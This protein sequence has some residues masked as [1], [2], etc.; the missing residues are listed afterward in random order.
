MMSYYNLD[1]EEVLTK[2]STNREG[3]KNIEVKNR[4]QKYGKNKLKIIKKQS[5]IKK[6]LCQFKDIMIIILILS[7]IVSFVLSIINNESFT[8]SIIIL[9]IVIINAIVGYIQESKADKALEELKKLQTTKTKVKR[10][11]RIIEI[12]SEDIV[13]GDI[14]VLEAGDTVP[15]DARIIYE[16]RLKC[17]ESALTG[18]SCNI[19]KTSRKLNELEIPLQNRI[20]MIYSGT[21][22]TYGKCQA[23][24]TSTGM[25]TEF[26]LIAKS[27][28]TEEKEITPLERKINDISKFLSIIIFII[29]FIMFI[30]GLIK[31]MKI[32]EVIM[33]SISLAVAAI[34]EGLPAVITI[35]L[36]LG[37]A[38]MARKKAIVRKLSSVETLGCTEVICSDK[39][40]TITQNKMTV[41]G[42]Y[43]DNK[44][45][46]SKEEI[47]ND[48]LEIM[49]LNNDVEK[50]ENKYI[51][52]STEIAL[53]NICEE[54]LVDI[55][56]LRN[57]FSRIDELPFDSDRKMMST[58]NKYDKC[59]KILTKGSFD[60]IINCCTKIYENGNINDLNEN[61]KQKL[62][63][64]E[65]ELSNKAYRILAF[66]FKEI[67]NKYTL[68]NNLENNLIFVGMTLMIDPPRIDVKEAINECK[69]A[70]IKPI[71]ITGDSL[72]T[73]I[74][75]SKEI[76]ILNDRKE[77][78]TG[79]E[80]DKL[81]KKELK[82]KVK[83]YSVYARVSPMN[84]LQI[85]NAWK[86]NNV[87]VA[88][89]GDGVNDAPA[90]KSAN[91]G[92]GM[93]ITGTEVS[94]NVSDIILADDSFSTIVTAVEEGRRIYDNIRNV[95]VYL[96]TGNIAEV[97]VVFI[98]MLFGIEIF[99]P[100]QLLYINLITDSIPAIALS[101][102]ECSDG[103]M[104]RTVK[105]NTNS[106][107]TPFLLAKIF[108]SSL[109]K[110][111]VILFVYF[112][113]INIYGV[114]T[115][116]T[117]SFLCL[118][119]LEMIFAFTCRNLKKNIIFEGIFKNK[120]MNK[121]M[122]VLLL[123]QTFIFVTPLKRI[124]NIENL[125][126]FQIIYCVIMVLTIFLIDEL[127][128]NLLV[129]IFKD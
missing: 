93:G 117:M 124:F 7:S 2:L 100:I 34:P 71:M 68:D 102:E 118:I 85:V 61:K 64:K 12:D 3:L 82:E 66:A 33:L 35:T 54:H 125:S 31:G 52:D 109:L 38:S 119:L 111:L 99:L 104:K 23:V 88:M 5:K 60:S 50:F 89:T 53:Y 80:I 115:A 84:K 57:K 56:D 72:D 24:V 6:F 128:K 18:E 15:A 123:I 48:L 122:I 103:I 41:V 79:I 46:D 83:D 20:N 29:I 36:S 14:L 96:I 27:L 74:A 126:L 110:T 127:T 114:N 120:I 43:F 121:S 98:G 58:I 78:I 77:A 1:I 92:I 70:N 39:T 73:A 113:S 81:S 67:D 30:I 22:I 19:S 97:L 55:N 101:F 17:D 37:V 42:I 4:L 26:G 87:I 105:K 28:D 8:D 40:G 49:A 62:K 45:I 69:L 59:I 44:L 106:F 21:N 16:A 112:T 91:I 95:L 116:I 94:K 108:L 107:F 76:G 63:N 129:K 75:I 32:N 65:Q 25:N 10:E 13:V 11:G 86:E 90:L 51:G 47:N 9:L